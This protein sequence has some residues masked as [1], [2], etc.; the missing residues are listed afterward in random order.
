MIE[1]VGQRYS[2]TVDF[3]P[4]LRL[5]LSTDTMTTAALEKPFVIVCEIKRERRYEIG[6]GGRDGN[7]LN[8]RARVGKKLY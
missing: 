6:G 4:K 8:M 3:P 1:P 5:D 2:Q 7:M